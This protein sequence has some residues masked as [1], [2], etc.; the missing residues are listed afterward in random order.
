[1]K[2]EEASEFRRRIF[3]AWRPAESSTK[4]R[5]F[6]SAFLQQPLLPS[7][8]LGLETGP[9]SIPWALHYDLALSELQHLLV[10]DQVRRP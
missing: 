8:R 5:R 9:Q 4:T 7:V 1:M 10:L 2:G 3:S 6:D